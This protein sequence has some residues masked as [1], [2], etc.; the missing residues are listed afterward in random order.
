MQTL[1]FL[2]L[3][4]LKHSKLFWGIFIFFFFLASVTLQ[5]LSI[6]STRLFVFCLSVNISDRAKSKVLC[7]SSK[8]L[9][10]KSALLS[11]TRLIRSELCFSSLSFHSAPSRSLQASLCLAYDS[12]AVG[13]KRVSLYCPPIGPQCTWSSVLFIGGW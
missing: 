4:K 9:L 7:I 8:P 13:A 10:F 5:N 2:M 6:L 3:K 1:I 12:Q 11:S